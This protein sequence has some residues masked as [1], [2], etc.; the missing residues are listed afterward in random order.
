MCP[1][2][3]CGSSLTK[4]QPRRVWGFAWDRALAPSWGAEN[5]GCA[6]SLRALEVMICGFGTARKGVRGAAVPGLAWRA[7]NPSRGAG[8]IPVPI[9]ILIPVPIPLLIPIPILIPIPGFGVPGAGGEWECGAGT[10]SAQLGQGWDAQPSGS[11]LPPHCPN[12]SGCPPGTSGCPQAH[13][14]LPMNIWLPPQHIWLPP[15]HIW[16]SPGTSGC[17]EPFSPPWGLM[18]WCP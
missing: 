13:L 8:L 11:A 17:S 9:P 16:L 7:L 2:T 4:V 3:S 6:E 1:G 10:G 15:R 14:A 5:P 12:A 18:D